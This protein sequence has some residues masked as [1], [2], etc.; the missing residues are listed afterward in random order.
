MKMNRLGC[1]S[2]FWE[3]P[4]LIYSK[5]QNDNERRHCL[6]KWIRP[7]SLIPPLNAIAIGNWSL[8]IITEGQFHF[9]QMQTIHLP[10][11]KHREALCF[12]MDCISYYIFI[13]YIIAG[14]EEYAIRCRCKFSISIRQILFSFSL[15]WRWCFGLSVV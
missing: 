14:A 3:R 13:W 2:K 4:Y 7:F 9:H 10:F 1:Y 6:K 5:H 12:F 8:L 11:S 15:T